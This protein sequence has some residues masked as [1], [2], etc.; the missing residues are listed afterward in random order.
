MSFNLHPL[1]NNGITAGSSSFS[2][3][4]L[5]C[6]CKASP[7]TVSL[8]SNI[9][10]NHA[11]GCS[12]C[13]KPSGA[14]FSIVGVVPRSALSVASGESKLYIVDKDAVIQRHACKEC[15]VHMFGR[16]EVDHAFHGLDF[17]HVELSKEKG[18]QEVQFAAFVSSVVEQGLVAPEEADK[19]RQQL[20]GLGLS[21]YDALSPGL[22]DAIAAFVAKKNGVLRESKL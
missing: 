3:G 1:I 5:S 9:A 19:V 18:W 11:C 15:G 20:K 2:G 10:H 17:V 16:I 13:W 8:T 22:M 7:V 12:K 6:H 14:I 21:T 4:K